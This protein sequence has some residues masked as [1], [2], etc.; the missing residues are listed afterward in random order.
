MKRNAEVS[1]QALM[2]SQGSVS[3]S[4]SF[5]FSLLFSLI[6][7]RNKINGF[8]IGRKR[9]KIKTTIPRK[10]TYKKKTNDKMKEM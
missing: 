6:L 5:A 10:K 9:K 4:I 2:R 7:K 3:A 1:S 8:T